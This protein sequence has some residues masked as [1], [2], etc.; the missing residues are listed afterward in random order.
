MT[1]VEEALAIVREG[2]H[3]VRVWLG[4]TTDEHENYPAR[5]AKEQTR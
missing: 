3:A 2:L 4:E 1:P 5:H